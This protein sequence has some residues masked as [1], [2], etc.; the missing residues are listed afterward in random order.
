MKLRRIVSVASVA[1]IAPLLATAPDCGAAVVLDWSAWTDFEDGDDGRQRFTNSDG[2]EI[3]YR[4]D[5][6]NANG[7]PRPEFVFGTPAIQSVAGV[8]DA[9]AI[10]QSAE[11]GDG[12]RHRITMRRGAAAQGLSITVGGIDGSTT[13]GDNYIDELQFSALLADGSEVAPTRI[14]VSST[15]D[16]TQI[17]ADRVVA[18]PNTGSAG[19]LQLFFDYAD[20]ERLEIN[21]FNSETGT[22]ANAAGNQGIWIG[23]VVETNITSLPVPE[24]GAVGLALLGSVVALG[25]RRPAG[26]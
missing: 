8:G 6:R 22:V 23:D 11:P 18:N 21:F 5:A 25:R 7:N 12:T 13:G 19:S 26:R 1:F 16:V 17:G 15:T 3:E 2:V 4:P 9:L 10:E 24:P 20:I 14:F